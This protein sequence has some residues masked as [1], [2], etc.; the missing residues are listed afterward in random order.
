MSWQLLLRA[1]N[2]SFEKIRSEAFKAVLNL[3]I[4][5]GGADTL[6]F[7]LQAVYEDIRS[8]VLTEAMG[9]FNQAWARSLLLDLFDDPAGAIRQESFEFFL[10][11]S[12]R[13]ELD[14]LERALQSNYSNMRFSAVDALSKRHTKKAQQLLVQALE[15]SEWEV[16]NLALNAILSEDAQ[17]VLVEAIGSQHADVVLRAAKARALHADPAAKEPLLKL[18]TEEEPREK[19][20]QSAWRESAVS[21]LEGLGILGDAEVSEAILPL[22]QSRHAS[23]RKAAAQALVG[24]ANETHQATFRS[25]LQHE[26]SQVKYRAA[27]ALA[28]AP[29]NGNSPRRTCR[30]AGTRLVAKA[31]Q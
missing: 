19:D 8:E 28:P 3:K 11:K 18:A 7:V 23:V 30:R 16:R 5:G 4:A 14:Y 6:R 1:L 15:D 27:F 17:S 22:L 31:C 13:S 24:L 29:A 20:K 2:D 26:D 12:K 10:K 21:A 25:L 9:Q